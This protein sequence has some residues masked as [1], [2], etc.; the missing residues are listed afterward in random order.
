M[1]KLLSILFASLILLSGL[2]FT[3][4]SHICCG[5]LAAVKYSV[6]GAKATCGMEEVNSYPANGVLHSNCCK[7]NITVCASDGN[8]FQSP[9]FIQEIASLDLLTY[10]I[11]PDFL[12]S[13][14][15]L[16]NACNSLTG[17]PLIKSYTPVDQSLL[18]VFLI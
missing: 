6:S 12:V 16:T 13:A 5:Q 18:C 11:A 17:P 1:K 9:T 4:A 3:V 10:A 15:V 2:H 14:P 8:Y 7:N